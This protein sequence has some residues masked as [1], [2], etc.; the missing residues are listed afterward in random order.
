MVIQN[1]RP[2]KF[3]SGK[4][5]GSYN[6]VTCGFACGCSL[7]S[8]NHKTKTNDSLV[9]FFTLQYKTDATGHSIDRIDENLNTA[10]K[11]EG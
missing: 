4:L 7:Y 10:T 5:I 2:I 3:Y 9:L 8:K 6:I 11:L 1:L